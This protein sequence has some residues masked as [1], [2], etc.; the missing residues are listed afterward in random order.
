MQPT[1]HGLLLQQLAGAHLQLREQ[2]NLTNQAL[3]DK[4]TLQD[5]VSYLQRELEIRDRDLAAARD[6]A[7]R[8]IKPFSEVLHESS[9]RSKHHERTFLL[10]RSES[11]A[12][13]GVCSRRPYICLIIDGDA[14]HFLPELLQ[15]GGRGGEMAAERIRREVSKFVAG[16]RHIPQSYVLKVQVFMN[17]RGFLS[18][19]SQCDRIPRDLIDSCLDRFFQSQPSWDLVDTG[20]LKESADTK[21]K[22]TTTFQKT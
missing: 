18:T 5:K 20:G 8:D 6:N 3:S 21:I 4:Q 16:R 10:D 19:V 22:G 1:A 11:V 12:S 15:A 13:A 14:N 17:R 2:E 7:D 9:D